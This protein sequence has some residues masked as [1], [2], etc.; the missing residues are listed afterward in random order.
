MRGATPRRNGPWTIEAEAEVYDNPWITVTDCKVVRP[1]GNNGQYGVVHFKNIAVG[2]LPIHDDGT[3]PLV[4]QHRFPHDAYSWEVPEG[5]G[6]RGVD[7]LASARRELAEETGL[8]ARHWLNISNFD[9]SNSVTD[10]KAACFLAWGLEEGTPAPDGDE[11]LAHRR[12]RFSDLH[13]MVLNGDI[14][15][16]LTIIMALKARALADRGRL[17]AHRALECLKSPVSR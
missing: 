1:D 9:I 6:A 7:P 15:D 5:G 16:S 10:E 17:P 8:R 4:G 11:V 2:V 13:E 3:V 14:S 12:V